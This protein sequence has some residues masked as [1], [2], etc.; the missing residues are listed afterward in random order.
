MVPFSLQPRICAGKMPPTVGRS[1]H[2]RDVMNI[3]PT[4]I[5]ECSSQGI[6]NLAKLTNEIN[7]HTPLESIPLSS[8]SPP[9]PIFYYSN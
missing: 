4:G 7:S 8:S 6:L 3:F 1:F 2:S 5:V 9:Y